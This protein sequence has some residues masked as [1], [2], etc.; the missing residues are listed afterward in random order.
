VSISTSSNV[1]DYLQSFRK[2][3]KEG[4]DYVC[5]VCRITFFRDQ[6]SLCIEKKYLEKYKSVEV[7][8][9]IHSYMYSSSRPNS[10][11]I[12]RLC[13]EK[14][15]RQQMS[16]RPVANDLERN[17]IASRLPVHE[18]CEFDVRKNDE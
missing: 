14:L 5:T 11:G 10:G 1:Q 12:C 17:L 7:T 4:H 18:N 13:P 9:R 8:A 16:S 6:V 3:I 15:K 2:S